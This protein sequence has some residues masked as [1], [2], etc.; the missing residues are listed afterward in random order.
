MLYKKYNT[1]KNP[2][3]IILIGL[4]GTIKLE[5]NQVIAPSNIFNKIDQ[6]PMRK[7]ELK[8]ENN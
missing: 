3:K 7:Q 5:E 6:M 2:F 8:D 4:D 1:T